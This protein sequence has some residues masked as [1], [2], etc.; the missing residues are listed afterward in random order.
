MQPK[1]DDD[2]EASTP[3]M[4]EATPLQGA[5]PRGTKRHYYLVPALCAMGALGAVARRA[6]ASSALYGRRPPRPAPTSK[7]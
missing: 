7:S 3:R 5:P 1:R 2:E 4:D 6:T